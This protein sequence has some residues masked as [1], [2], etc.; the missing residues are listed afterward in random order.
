[1]GPLRFRQISVVTNARI[2]FVGTSRS[3]TTEEGV[4]LVPRGSVGS[5]I[6]SVMQ[7]GSVASAGDP[8]VHIYKVRREDSQSSGVFLTPPGAGIVMPDETYATTNADAFLQEALGTQERRALQKIDVLAQ[9]VADPAAELVFSCEPRG[10]RGPLLLRYMGSPAVLP[11]FGYL[12]SDIEKRSAAV[13]QPTNATARY[14][15]SSRSGKRASVDAAD[16]AKNIVRQRVI[17]PDEQ[18]RQVSTGITGRE[19]S[20]KPEPEAL[21][22]VE[23]T[24]EEQTEMDGESLTPA[25]LAAAEVEAGEVKG[26]GKGKDP[27]KGGDK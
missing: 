21:L 27:A 7:L 4:F 1:M 26:R 18:Q 24:P 22:A 12:A 9:L 25:E 2:I 3:E 19:E 5:S 17:K 10:N 11:L 14:K 15:V 20:A 16:A 13:F 6:G 23:A 8:Q